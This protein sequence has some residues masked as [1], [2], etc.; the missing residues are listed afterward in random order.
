MKGITL[1]S[2]RDWNDW[3]FQT[4]GYALKRRATRILS[5]TEQAPGAGANA[6]LQESYETRNGDLW[7]FMISHVSKEYSSTI[8]A[9]D[10]GMGNCHSLWV[11]LTSVFE[12]SN[13]SAIN[14]GVTKLTS[15][16]S[17]GLTVPKY[18]ADITICC[19]HLK[20][21]IPAA[22]TVSEFIDI[23]YV[24]SLL[25]GLPESYES[26]NT[27]M[28]MNDAVTPAELRIRVLAE[29]A[30]MTT[31]SYSKVARGS[32]LQ[33]GD[34]KVCTVPGCPKPNGHTSEQCWIT[35]PELKRSFSKRR[36]AKST[37][38]VTKAESEST[39]ERHAWTVKRSGQVYSVS[40]E[41]SQDYIVKPFNMDS[42]CSTTIVNS[43]EGISSFDPSDI[44][45]FSL[46]D[47]SG[48]SSTGTGV[49]TGKGKN[50]KVHVVPTFGENLLSIPQLYGR[51]VATVFHPKLGIM[52]AD[53]DQM[54]VHCPKPLGTGRYVDGTFLIDL[55]I[56]KKNNSAKAI[57][58]AIA[59]DDATARTATSLGI[60]MAVT[61][62]M[63]LSTKSI[64][65]Y[66]R[67]GYI[68][69]R[70]IVDAIHHGLL[71]G[72]NL[73][74]NIQPSDFPISAVEEAQLAKS[75]A[76]AHTNLSG[77]KHSTRPYQMLH[78]DFK[79]MGITSW[80]GATG[81]STIVDDFSSRIHKIPLSSKR[82]FVERFKSWVAQ[83]VTSRG[84]KISVIRSDNG[85][86][87]KN[88]KFEEFLTSISARSE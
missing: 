74:K 44:Q 30:A 26:F 86:E 36:D 76:K 3:K 62:V 87:I 68:N 70:K 40:S 58:G 28:R 51:N 77:R 56:A 55:V 20:S 4:E 69:P 84:Y 71:T 45:Q 2:P 31:T 41:E 65:W 5:G 47:R 19:E 72:I 43:P 17:S 23:L 38:E 82:T 12:G 13:K 29:D 53:A 54:A 79:H 42:A 11:K 66:K 88:Y 18:V 39:V 57:K 60:P 32:A 80:G 14:L 15:F 22:M 59:T 1:S 37:K 16:T 10:V 34:K 81:S 50:L 67:L 63:Q 7:Y 25:K 35:H 85:T 73:P 21:L 46:A 78:I 48:V 33:V 52:I 75:S 64:L 49:I 9:T 83:F 6:A 27:S 61:P 8:Q 24:Q